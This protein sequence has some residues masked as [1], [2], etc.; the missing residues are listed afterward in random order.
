MRARSPATIGLLCLVGS[1]LSL[2]R[3]VWIGVVLGTGVAMLSTRGLR[4]Y[5]VPVAAASVAAIAVSLALI[6]GLSTSVTQ[7]AN[8]KATVWDRKNLARAALNMVE[9]KPLF[10]FGWGRFTSDS[11]DYFQ[12]AFDYPLT[13]TE[14]GV[15]N[16]PLTYAVDL[17][18]VGM[19]LWLVGVVFGIGAALTTR[20]P[21]DLARWRVG[22]VAIATAYLVVMNSVPPTAWLNRSIWLFAGVVYSGR[23]IASPSSRPIAHGSQAGA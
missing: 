9:A 12:Q 16:T 7:R 17:G 8:D 11:R 19:T 1:F 2:E 10:G 3:S 6:P 22:L 21:P 15:H 23:Y 13:A 20:G 18:L 4:R 5:L 14:A